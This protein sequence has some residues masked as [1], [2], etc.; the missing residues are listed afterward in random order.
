[1]KGVINNMTRNHYILIA[2]AITNSTNGVACIDKRTFIDAMIVI[3]ENDNDAFD[4]QR[5]IDK[6]EWN[7]SYKHSLD[8]EQLEQIANIM[9]KGNL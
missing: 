5:F 4:K 3:F 2:D 7:G 1:M 8:S 6:I 9:N